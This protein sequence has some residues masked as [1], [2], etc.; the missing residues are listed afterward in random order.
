M[1]VRQAILSLLR[2]LMGSAAFPGN[3]D[4]L[5]R[6]SSIHPV[7]RPVWKGSQMAS[8]SEELLQ[9]CILQV[10]GFRYVELPKER[11]LANIQHRPVSGYKVFT[12]PSNLPVFGMEQKTT[13]R[14]SVKARPSCVF[15]L[16]RYDEY[17]GDDPNYPSS[18][19]WAATL[20]DR[21]WEINLSE[22]AALSIGQSASW[23]PHVRPFFRSVHESTNTGPYLGFTDFLHCVGAVASFLDRVK[24]IPPESTGTESGLEGSKSNIPGCETDEKPDLT[25][26]DNGTSESGHIGHS[27]HE[28]TSEQLDLFELTFKERE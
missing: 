10:S 23:N 1:Q 26:T 20:Y 16:S 2:Q 25:G 17:N 21:E 24:G 27:K 11:T 28:I 5:Q 7:S 9:Q 14:Y 19:M 8:G 3:S 13:L 22:N 6:I 18:T 15:E 12:N 4:C